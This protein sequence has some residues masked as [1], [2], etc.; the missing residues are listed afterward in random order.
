MIKLRVKR[1][2]IAHNPWN[3]DIIFAHDLSVNNNIP[4]WPLISV[5]LEAMQPSKRLAQTN[6]MALWRNALL[7][8]IYHVHPLAKTLVRILKAWNRM[9]MAGEL[10]C[11][12]V[13]SF[14][15]EVLA[16]LLLD[17]GFIPAD[18]NLS[19]ALATCLFAI[20]FPSHVPALFFRRSSD[21]VNWPAPPDQS[22]LVALTKKVDPTA[23]KAGFA[24]GGFVLVDPLAPFS[25]LATRKPKTFEAWNR[26]ERHATGFF[27]FL[28]S[29]KVR[30]YPLNVA[31]KRKE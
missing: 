21:F 14:T 29:K 25:N 31:V 11:K 12:S 9:V 20:A 28:G 3:I 19:K 26:L 1:N 16:L 6:S 30:P 24:E 18:F 23:M 22:Q 13:N 10:E 2:G 27:E 4:Q 15:L 5:E 8:S 7:Q 17:N